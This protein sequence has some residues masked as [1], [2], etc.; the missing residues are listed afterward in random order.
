MHT[1][2]GECMRHALKVSFVQNGH[3][4]QRLYLFK[5]SYASV[6]VPAVQQAYNIKASR[7]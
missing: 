6:L 7:R 2:W 4:R 5:S 3:M 1:T